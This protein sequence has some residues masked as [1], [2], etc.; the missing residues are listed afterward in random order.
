MIISFFFRSIS[1]VGA[2]PLSTN[3]DD[4]NKNTKSTEE[5]VK[6]VKKLSDP[7]GEQS[8]QNVISYV[9]PN[10]MDSDIKPSIEKLVKV[11]ENFY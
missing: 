9:L 3:I 2:P 7:T 5:P 6:K 4:R 1:E 11:C 8:T 10:E